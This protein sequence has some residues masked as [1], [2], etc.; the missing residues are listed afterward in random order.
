MTMASTHLHK[1]LWGLAL[2]AALAACRPSRTPPTP[3]VAPTAR[4]ECPDLAGAYAAD[5]SVAH[6][7]LVLNAVRLNHLTGGHPVVEVLQEPQGDLTLR[8]QQPAGERQVI[9]TR[10]A[11]GSYRCEGGYLL[12]DKRFNYNFYFRQS[13]ARSGGETDE[14]AERAYALARS[15]SGDLIVKTTRYQWLSISFWAPGGTGGRVPGTTTE[16]VSYTTW[17]RLAGAAGAPGQP[18]KPRLSEEAL[19]QQLLAI[20][21][22][23][24]NHTQSKT[25]GGYRY[26]SFRWNASDTGRA[27]MSALHARVNRETPAEVRGIITSPTING[28]DVM[29]A[30]GALA[31]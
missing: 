5:D 3:P 24:A 12:L 16:Q 11:W 2:L 19:V 22:G 1:T 6:Y 26:L 17:Q 21:P 31:P 27:G 10:A 29:I 8:P 13:R 7:D 28:F 23:S 4:G 25:Q 15:P 14:S 30:T 20:L 9:G 18:D